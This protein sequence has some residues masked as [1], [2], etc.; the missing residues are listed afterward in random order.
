MITITLTI[1]IEEKIQDI[2]SLS[3]DN[4]KFIDGG[5]YRTLFI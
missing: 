4:Y 2:I 5:K 3:S 1:S